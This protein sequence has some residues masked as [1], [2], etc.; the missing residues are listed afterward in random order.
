MRAVLQLLRSTADIQCCTYYL[1]AYSLAKATFVLTTVDKLQISTKTIQTVQQQKS[2]IRKT[3]NLTFCEMCDKKK[4]CDQ[5]L[6]P[7]KLKIWQNLKTYIV[8]QLKN[9]KTLKLKC[10]NTQKIQI[11]TILKNSNCDNTR[12]LTKLKNWSC[13]KLTTSNCYKT[14]VLKFL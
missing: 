6:T 9:S 5:N 12:L 13:E 14:W 2:R 10:D 1:P 7:E 3:P 4:F 11:V 8:T